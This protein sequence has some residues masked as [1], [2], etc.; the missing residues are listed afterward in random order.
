MKAELAAEVA[1]KASLEQRGLGVITSSG[2]LLT[3]VFA[4]LAAAR[5]RQLDLEGATLAPLFAVL[6]AFVLAAACGIAVNWTWKTSAVPVDG[7][8]GLASFLDAETFTGPTR[9]VD[10]RIAQVHVE[11]VGTLRRVNNAKATVLQIGLALEAL[12]ILGVAVI[13]SVELA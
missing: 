2:T 6:P 10:R 9:A 3:L 7:E 11:Q 8:A 5:G 12:A 4:L 1:R 13:A